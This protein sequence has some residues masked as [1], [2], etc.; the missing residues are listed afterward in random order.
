MRKIN[1]LLVEHGREQPSAV[2]LYM[3]LKDIANAV[4]GA[5]RELPLEG[6]IV[7]LVAGFESEQIVRTWNDTAIAGNAFFVVGR[8]K[9]G[10]RSLDDEEVARYQEVFKGGF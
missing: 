1:A 2:T 4:G 8:N 9:S 7:A 3:D 6:S 10:Y 5:V